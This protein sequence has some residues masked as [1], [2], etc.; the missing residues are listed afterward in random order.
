[1]TW[2]GT[3][4]ACV[5]IGLVAAGAAIPPLLIAGVALLAVS[6]LSIVIDGRRAPDARRLHSLRTHDSILSVG[7][8]N[9]VTLRIDGRDGARTTVRDEVPVHA[10]ASA[11][12]WRTTLPASLSYTVTPRARGE[13]K[14]GHTVVRAEGPLRLGWRQ[15]NAGAPEVLAVDANIAAVRVY[16]ALARRG[17][18]AELGVRT[19]RLRSQGT[20]FERIREAVPDDSLR[21]INWK[22]TARSGRLMASELMPE[23]SQPVIACI[24]HGRLMGVGAGELTKLDHAI[25]AALLL[26]H[27]ALRTGD[28]AG[29]LAFADG[30]TMRLRP[31][32]G[33][34]QLRS[35]LDAV[36]P[37]QPAETEVDYVSGFAGFE[38]WQRRRSLVVIF[39]DVLDRD[40]GAA[41]VSQ[42]LRLRR[43]HLPLVVTVRDPALDDIVQRTPRTANEMYARAVAGG[44]IDDR[45]DTLRLLQ[46]SGVDTLDADARSLSPRLV[47]RYLALK[48]AARL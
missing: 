23:R 34:A 9:P 29:L 33:S 6:A 37:L 35:F 8:E 2:R 12:S 3:A 11:Q 4:L 18:L 30:V 1:V 25:N 36:R 41:L 26:V 22:A 21:A 17:Q 5:A 45:D 14:L 47:N 42:C 38:R 44:L 13:L 43:R 28:R 10:H 27:V 16:E 20:E 24:D 48:R 19:A 7:V 32:A 15:S 39:T 31:E 40:Q 46:A